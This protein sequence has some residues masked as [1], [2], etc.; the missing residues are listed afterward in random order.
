MSPGV[1]IVIILFKTFLYIVG[2]FAGI[3]VAVWLKTRL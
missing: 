3:A 2:F 1:S